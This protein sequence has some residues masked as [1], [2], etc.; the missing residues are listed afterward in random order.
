MVRRLLE[1]RGIFPVS[2]LAVDGAKKLLYRR[3]VEI[4]LFILD[5]SVQQGGEFSLTSSN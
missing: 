4:E 5:Y 3:T 1:E 2:G